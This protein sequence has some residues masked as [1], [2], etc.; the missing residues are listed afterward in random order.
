MYSNQIEEWRQIK[1][2]EEYWIS[3]FG[4]IIS[5]KTKDFMRPCDTGGKYIKGKGSYKSLTLCKNN[6]KYRFLV[7]R[8]VAE[9]FIQ[10]PK[11]NK[12]LTVNHK[13]GIKSDNNV[14]NLE[15]LTYS[16]NTK[17]AYRIGLKTQVGSNNNKSKITDE[18]AL[19]IF[20]ATGTQKSI[21]ERFSVSQTCVWSIK[22][23]KQWVHIHKKTQ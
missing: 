3:S 20:N 21:G 2:F 13:N 6:I 16:E 19:K 15:W 14:S 10:K 5:K 7:H 23:K 1:G 8:L 18:I 12:R 11:S 17:H 4:S 9:N 22:S